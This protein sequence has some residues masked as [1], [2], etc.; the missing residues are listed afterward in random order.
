MVIRKILKYSFLLMAVALCGMFIACGDDDNEKQHDWQVFLPSTIVAKGDYLTT[1]VYGN[2]D[3]DF[4]VNYYWDGTLIQTTDKRTGLNYLVVDQKSGDHILKMEFSGEVH[5]VTEYFI[6]VYDK[7]YGF[8]GCELI[9][10]NR[11]VKNGETIQG[12][13]IF[14]PS[15]GTGG[16][17]G[18][19]REVKVYIDNKSDPEKALQTI[20]N[21]P[22]DFRIP[23]S[24]L[25]K[26]NH[27]LIFD[28][29]GVIMGGTGAG[30]GWVALGGCTYNF[31]VTE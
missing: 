18:N 16:W 8:I 27:K 25:S 7:D 12:K 6:Q 23:I 21:D 31:T 24:G 15:T 3:Y 10:S 19:I 17:K 4:K 1:S 28:V 2:S 30:G 13:V 5:G 29:D 26:G 9:P 11:E 22:F 20:T 14:I